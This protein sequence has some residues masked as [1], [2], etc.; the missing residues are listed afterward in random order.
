MLLFDNL[1][2]LSIIKNVIHRFCIVYK[3]TLVLINNYDNKNVFGNLRKAIS[4]FAGMIW[5]QSDARTGM[6]YWR[7]EEENKHSDHKKWSWKA[8]VFI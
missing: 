7:T 2:I 5:N 6:I 8:Q 3:N 4:F 1:I